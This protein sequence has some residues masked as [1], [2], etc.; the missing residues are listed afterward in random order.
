MNSP[1]LGATGLP[2]PE[3]EFTAFDARIADAAKSLRRPLHPSLAPAR[4]AAIRA[5]ARDPD[6]AHATAARTLVE[7]A[8]L[9]FADVRARAQD[10][11][12]DRFDRAIADAART[13][14]R[15]APAGLLEQVRASA[16]PRWTRRALRVVALR[17]FALAAAATLLAGLALFFA[18]QNQ[19]SAAPHPALLS[20]SALERAEA[21]E[22]A[23]ATRAD[24]LA[25][26]VAADP[27][28]ADD[29]ALAPLLEEAAFLDGAITECRAA[30]ELSQAH[31]HLREQLRV[32]GER[33]VE[34]LALLAA[35][36]GNDG[37]AGR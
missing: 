16:R 15:P 8:P 23:L 32:L 17:R 13:L 36:R 33:R 10:E 22:S 30:L 26:Q 9:S 20:A 12:P 34:L 2:P 7:P 25:A 4:F 37:G 24:S 11:T 35:A 19:A 1:D 6:V 28:L 3:P 27:A 21:A 5:A 31:S 14:V 29:E 18:A